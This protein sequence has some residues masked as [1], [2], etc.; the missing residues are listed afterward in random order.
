MRKVLLSLAAPLF[1]IVGLCSMIVAPFFNLASMDLAEQPWLGAHALLAIG[2]ALTAFG[3]W[4]WILAW[5]LWF[6]KK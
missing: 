5:K 3:V 4:F 6:P 1:L 2:F